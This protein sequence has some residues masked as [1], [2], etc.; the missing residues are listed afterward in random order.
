M[1]I[2]KRQSKQREAALVHKTE[3]RVRFSETDAMQ[4][5]WHGEYTRYFEDAREDFGRKYNGL[6]YD[7]I[8]KS[9]IFTP[10]VELHINFCNPLKMN[11]I[12]IVEIHYIKSLA[13]KICFD[14]FIYRKTDN[15]LVAKG[16]TTQMFTDSKGELLLNP[17]PYYLQWQKKWGI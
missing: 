5:V 3:I 10:V 1:S 13:A 15:L 11:D 17:P 6:G 8:E 16:F 7:D 4:V 9:G 2:A 12:A 14:Y